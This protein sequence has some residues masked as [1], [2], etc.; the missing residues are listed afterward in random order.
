[1]DPELILESLRNARADNEHYFLNGGCWELFVFLRRLFPEAKPYH[2]W[3]EFVGHVATGIGGHLYDIRGR[4]KRPDLYQPMTINGW[5]SLKR[6]HK[7]HRW[8]KTY[9]RDDYIW[10]E[11]EKSGPRV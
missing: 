4:V 8:S 6:G 10:T 3:T 1:M 2:T 11:A 7:P 5:P 9:P